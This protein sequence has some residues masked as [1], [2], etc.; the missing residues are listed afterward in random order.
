MIEYKVATLRCADDVDSYDLNVLARE[1]WR[2]I[3]SA[4]VDYGIS[5]IMARGEEGYDRRPVL[6]KKG[7]AV[8]MPDGTVV[9]T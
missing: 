2:V 4:A 7:A 8:V 5:I 3:T 9:K 1:G 6:V